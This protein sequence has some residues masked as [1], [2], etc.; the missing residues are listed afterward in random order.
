MCGLAR[1][2][3]DVLRNEATSLGVAGGAKLNRHGRRRTLSSSHGLKPLK[4][5]ECPEEASLD[6]GLVAGEFGEGVR[7]SGIG[8]VSLAENDLV[9]SGDEVV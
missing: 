8:F 3:E 7:P 6:G 5:V 9:R 4:L 1:Q 2:S